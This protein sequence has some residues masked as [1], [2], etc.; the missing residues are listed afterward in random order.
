MRAREVIA[1]A[2]TPDGAPIELA[3]EAGHHVVRVRGVAL[4]SSAVHGSE[5]AM[6]EVGCRGLAGRPGARVMVGGLGLGFTL[7]A[8][9]DAL[10]S[11]AEVEVIELVAP[12]V[13]WNRGPVA[14]RAGRPLDDPRA[15]VVVADVVTHLRSRPGPYDAILLDVDNGP[16]A[17]S[18]PGNAWLYREAGLAACRAALRRPG[19]LVVWSAFR[20]PPFEARLH[21]AGFEVEVV[22]VRARGRTGKGSRHC[23]FVG[24]VRS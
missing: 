1:R 8:A 21:A 6:A 5:E 9:L 12:L 4:M 7:R 24:R 19:A 15:T 13:D 10:A 18:A 11:D 2:V 14:D 16:D 23:L 20:S 22:P 3:I 17:L